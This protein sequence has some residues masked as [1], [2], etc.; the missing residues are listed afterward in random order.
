MSLGTIDFSLIVDGAVIIVEAILHPLL[1]TNMQGKSTNVLSQKQ[2]DETVLQSA[3]RMMSTTAF[4]QIIILIVNLPI[5]S[6]VG[7]EGKMFDQWHKQ[8]R[9]PYLEH[10]F[11]HL[12]IPMISSVF[13]AE[14]FS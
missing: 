9:L 11:F 12:L 14:N 13:R 8:F 1:T 10:S 6:L 5:L 3:K 4:G 2:L 7:I